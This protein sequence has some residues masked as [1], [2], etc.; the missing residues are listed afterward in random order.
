MT[1]SNAMASQILQSSASGYAGYAAS[2]LLERNPGLAESLPTEPFSSWKAHLTQRVM[3]LAAALRAGEPEMFAARVRWTKRTFDAR[4]IS[5]EFLAAS[6]QSL[7]TVLS[8]R[9][10]ADASTDACRL[11]EISLGALSNDSTDTAADALDASK[12]DDR[13]A[14][15]YLQLIL[16]GNISAAIDRILSEQ[17]NGTDI[18]HL[19]TRV[20]LPAQRE[21]GRLWHLG[22]LT[23]AEEHLVT[24]ATARAMTLLADRAPS[25]TPNG[26]TM[27]AAAASGNVHDVGLRAVSDLFQL[28][29][30]RSLCLGSDIPLR[31]LPSS[32]VYFDADLLLLSATLSTHVQPIERSIALI[33]EHCDKPILIMVGGAAFDEIDGLWK[34]VGADRYSLT[35]DEAVRIGA[36]SFNL[37]IN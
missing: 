11:I 35:I 17:S 20:L 33:R 19:Y 24:A 1:T 21:V 29:G 2:D 23:I 4:G 28:Q 14:L 22:E 26:R 13:L 30:W 12:A 10:P 9:L 15:R 31:E 18:T 36:E 3:E 8:E 16:E 34:K 32:L 7:R 27:V 25:R 6:L 5:A 37:S